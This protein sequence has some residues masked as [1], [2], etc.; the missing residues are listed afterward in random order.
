[1]SDGRKRELMAKLK[2][3]LELGR[4]IPNS[5]PLLD[6]MRHVIN[7]D[8]HI[9]AEGAYK[10]DRVM[11]SALAAEAWRAWL[12]PVLRAKHM[13][14]ARSEGIERAGGEQPVDQLIL[15]YL[16]KSNITL[17]ATGRRP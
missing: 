3:G 12:L 11:A 5:V 17:P 15:N 7:D 4:I 14:R 6:E 16:R 10:D 9:A 1:M 2:D 8:G 13:T